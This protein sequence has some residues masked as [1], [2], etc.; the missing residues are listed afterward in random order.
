MPVIGGRDRMIEICLGKNA[1]TYL[2]TKPKITLKKKR[3]KRLSMCVAQ[4]TE[5]LPR[6]HETQSSILN[7]E[8]KGNK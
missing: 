4:V 6:K 2:K 8:K 3:S 7:V 1:R 5:C